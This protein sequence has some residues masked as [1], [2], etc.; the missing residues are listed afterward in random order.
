MPTPSDQEVLIR[1]EATS[2]S[3]ADI[4]IRSFTVP[5]VLWIPARLALGIT[6]PK[7]KILGV[8]LSGTIVAIGKNVRRFKVGDE[9]YAAS[10]SKFGGY[11]EYITLKE[12]EAIAL[13][14]K[15]LTFQQ[16]AAIPIGGRTALH[17][18]NLARLKPNMHVL[19]Y[20][21]SGS[22]GTYAV[23]I[24]KYMGAKVTGVCGKHNMRMVE[25][26]G[27]DKVIDYTEPDFDTQLEKYDVIFVAIN[28]VPF[29]L[30]NKHLR[31][32]GTYINISAA[33]KT[34]QMIYAALVERKKIIAGGNVP[35]TSETLEMLTTIVEAG[36]LNPVIDRS[37]LMDCIQEAHQY[38]G[39]GHK[40][41][42]VVLQ[43]T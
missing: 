20:G 12:N 13:K 43:I 5:P 16:A 39:Q 35:N 29:S 42:N 3:A 14:P 41:G 7:L 1:V 18:L 15:R 33:I 19:V 31:K 2:V 6:R 40:K 34:P 27:A 36:K 23:Q 9:V 24:A 17:F 22:V 38:V 28:K 21:A 25:D 30:C 26:I 37:Y 8:E 32:K 4:R 11:A 10:L